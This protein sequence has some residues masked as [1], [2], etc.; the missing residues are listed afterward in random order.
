MGLSFSAGFGNELFRSWFDLSFFVIFNLGNCG[1][2]FRASTDFGGK[3]RRWSVERFCLLGCLC[4]RPVCVLCNRRFWR[5]VSC[6]QC[7]APGLSHLFGL[8]FNRSLRA[9]I[10]TYPFQTG[11]SRLHHFFSADSNSFKRSTFGDEL[12]A[13]LLGGKLGWALT[14]AFDT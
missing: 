10:C 11:N 7:L 12:R 9:A 14:G 4:L 2:R 13:I 5:K 1:F 3:F 8:C 6:A